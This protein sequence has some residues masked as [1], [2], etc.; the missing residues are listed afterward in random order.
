MGWRSPKWLQQAKCILGPVPTK[1]FNNTLRMLSSIFRFPGTHE[2]FW[3]CQC[4]GSC[5]ARSHGTTGT[6]ACAPRCGSRHTSA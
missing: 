1:S 5:T 3:V 2:L 6:V 4:R